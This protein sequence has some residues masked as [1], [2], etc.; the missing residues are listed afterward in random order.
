VDNSLDDPAPF[1][2]SN[3]V[4]TFSVLEAVRR[5]GVRLHHGSTD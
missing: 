4:G 1:L 3:I 2:R 5:H